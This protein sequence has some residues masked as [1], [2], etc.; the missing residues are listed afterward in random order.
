MLFSIENGETFLQKFHT[1]V[2]VADF[3]MNLSLKRNLSGVRLLLGLLPL[4]DRDIK[5]YRCGAFFALLKKPV[6]KWKNVRKL[7]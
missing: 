2:N 1:N 4:D 5:Q 3:L 6:F 7:T